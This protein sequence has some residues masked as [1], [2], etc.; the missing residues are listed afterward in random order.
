MAKSSK[1]TGKNTQSSR[2]SNGKQTSSSDNGRK[3]SATKK[4]D[5]SAGGKEELMKLFEHGLKDMFWVEKT[6]TRAI[7]KM[8]KKATSEDLIN[9]LEDHL[10]VTEDQVS[11]LERIFEAID[12]TPRAKKCIGM[13]GIIK[14]GEE[15]MEE[16]QGPAIDAAIITAAQKVEH[17]EM[18]SYM[19]LINLARTLD[20]VKEA[21]ILEQILQEEMEADNILAKI[22]ATSAHQLVLNEA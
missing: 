11:K 7:P 14:E 6:L 18:S 22:A 4:Q 1:S 8:M 20:M 19:S 21:G 17:Y 9:A 10:E 2:S 15:I 16:F 5:S 12:K 3:L 13:E